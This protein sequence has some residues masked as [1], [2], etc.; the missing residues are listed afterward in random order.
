[1]LPDAL[2]TVADK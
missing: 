1:M 2:V